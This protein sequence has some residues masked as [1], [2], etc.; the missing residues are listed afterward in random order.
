MAIYIDHCG[1]TPLAREVRDAM[2]AHMDHDLFGNPAAFHHIVGNAAFVAVESAR[3]EIAG[4]V[5]AQ[6]SWVYFTGG[7]SEANNLVVHGFVRKFTKST[8]HGCR[9]LV[10]SSE[11]KSALDP[12]LSF[13]ASSGCQVEQ[14]SIKRHDGTLDINYLADVLARNP[15]RLPTLI[16]VM[17]CNNEIP[18]KNDL[19]SIA[20]LCREH[21]AFWHCDAVQ[22]FVR[23]ALDVRTLGASSVVIAPHKF[24][25]PKGIG[26]LIIPERSP[27]LRLDPPIK[28]GDQER[29]LRPG[30]L[31][32]LA[33]AGA[34]AAV[35]LH[36]KRRN[37]LVQH[38]RACDE[39][40]ATTM[41]Q[42]VPGF[43]LTVPMSS[44]C[45]G[46]INFYINGV[47][48][49]SLIHNVSTDVCANRGASCSGAGG[50]KARH[51]PTAL[52]LPVEIAA[53]VIRVS[54]GFAN[55]LNDAV[56]AAEIFANAA[57]K[58]AG[59]T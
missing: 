37:Q 13:A 15:Q 46:I 23:N 8:Q 55:T 27:M 25:G 11:H 9:I 36:E 4:A 14:L 6:P 49:E 33:I 31:N 56:V 44:T 59:K 45:P 57:K 40:F 26:I 32:T 22:G 16:V 43:C 24:Y 42:L 19:E 28:G 21:G 50:E 2:V 41:S 7:A 34:A 12:V 58:L 47:D 29:K 35:T 5:N 48:A 10:G 39:S 52:G 17:A 38:L 51:V 1:T 18:A 20:A 54:F 53:N 3:R 30:T